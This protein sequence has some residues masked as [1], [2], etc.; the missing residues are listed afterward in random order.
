MHI[1]R[2]TVCEQLE[3]RRKPVWR[4]SYIGNTMKSLYISAEKSLENL[5]TNYIDILYIH[6]TSGMR[7]I[8]VDLAH[9]LDSGT[10][11][12]V[13]RTGRITLSQI[14][15]CSTLYVVLRARL[16]SRTAEGTSAE[17]SSDTLSWIVAKANMYARLTGRTPFVVYQCA[18][19]VLQRDLEREIIPMTRAEGSHLTS[20]TASRHANDH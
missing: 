6:W 17:G 14:A 10:G 19:S 2:C 1:G 8:G 16:S 13:S 5:R 7:L 9:A 11:P 20:N 18:W 15:R 4:T 3:T 12:V